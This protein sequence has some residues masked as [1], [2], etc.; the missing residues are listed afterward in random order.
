[1]TNTKNKEIFAE[2]L[3][4][5]RKMR[6]P[7]TQKGLAAVL[8]VGPV[9]L[10]RWKNDVEFQELV[11]QRARS[12]LMAELPDV[13]HMIMEKAKGGDFR[14]AKMVLELTGR[15][16]ERITVRQEAAIKQVAEWKKER[17]GR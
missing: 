2:W 13:M 7:G 3:A 11:Y 6:E 10:S 1:M 17:F 8:D 4:M 9:T 5:P 15:Y 14:F 16:S 12:H